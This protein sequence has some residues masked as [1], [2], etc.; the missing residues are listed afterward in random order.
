MLDEILVNP[1]GD[2]PEGLMMFQESLASE[3]KFMQSTKIALDLISKYPDSEQALQ[4]AKDARRHAR[5]AASFGDYGSAADIVMDIATHLNDPDFVKQCIADAMK[6][7]IDAAE[8]EY[9]DVAADIAERLQEELEVE[10]LPV[11]A[12]NWQNWRITPSK[13]TPPS[14][15]DPVDPG[16]VSDDPKG[17]TPTNKPPS[18]L[19]IRDGESLADWLKRVNDYYKM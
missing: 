14:P 2:D 5:K 9:Y 11:I 19:Q 1:Y 6:Y 8:D 15:F 12:N 7:S 13:P 10:L 17:D 16:P 4:A 18:D 3:G